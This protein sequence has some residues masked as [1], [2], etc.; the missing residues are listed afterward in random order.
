VNFS[1]VDSREFG[2]AIYQVERFSLGVV[3]LHLAEIG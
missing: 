1:G 3:A 2:L